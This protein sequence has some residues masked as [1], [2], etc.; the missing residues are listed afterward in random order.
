MADNSNKKPNLFSRIGKF[1]KDCRSEFKKL[2]WPTKKQLVKNSSVV[3]VSMIVVGACLSLV[4]V[5]LSKGLY[6][7]KDLIDLIRPV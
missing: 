1:F 6:Y 3:L 7:L 4:D 2:V 5:G